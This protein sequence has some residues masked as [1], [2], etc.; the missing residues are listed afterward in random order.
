MV[1]MRVSLLIAVVLIFVI[2]P[3]VYA[4][5]WAIVTVKDVPDY[6]VAGKPFTL[7][8]SVRQHGLTLIDGLDPTVIANKPNHQTE[9]N[10]KRRVRVFGV[11]NLLSPHP[12]L[13]RGR[14][15]Y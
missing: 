13:S 9:V 6:A 3:A 8:F 11:G 15:I 1:R 12:T 10:A 7:T 2:V 14:G 4:G 5:G